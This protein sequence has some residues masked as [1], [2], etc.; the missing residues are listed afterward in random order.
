MRNAPLDCK[1]EDGEVIIRIGVDTLSFAAQSR[2]PFTQYDDTVGDWRKFWIVSD[3]DQFALDVRQEMIR[4]E[5][6][7]SSPLTNLLDKMFENALDQGSLGVQEA[8]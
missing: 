1:I 7:G 3:A 4:E 2:E 8:K 6:D 5:E